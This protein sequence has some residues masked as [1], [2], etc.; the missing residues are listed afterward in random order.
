[1]AFSASE[2]GAE[3]ARNYLDA[4]EHV[5]DMLERFPK[6]GRVFRRGQTEI[7]TYP[8]QSHRV[9]YTIDGDTVWIVRIL[10][11]ARDAEQLLN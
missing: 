6:S 8:C 4:F 3:I 9:F 11:R 10:H 7:R 2:F 1:M 5:C